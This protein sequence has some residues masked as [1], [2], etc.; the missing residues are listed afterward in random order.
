MSEGVETGGWILSE[1]HGK[2]R[3]LSRLKRAFFPLYCLH[4][5]PRVFLKRFTKVAFFVYFDLTKPPIA[6]NI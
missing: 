6:A 5:F 4:N 3:F 2:C 1:N